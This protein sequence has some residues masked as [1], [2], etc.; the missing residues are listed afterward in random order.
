MTGSKNKGA[1]ESSEMQSNW[2][3]QRRGQTVEAGTQKSL[4]MRSKRVCVIWP[5]QLL[6]LGL[7]A[8]CV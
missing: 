3:K 1:E 6:C 7:N 2:L 8:F 5:A 4:S